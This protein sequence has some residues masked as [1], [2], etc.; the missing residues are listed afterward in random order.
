MNNEDKFYIIGVDGG[1]SKREVFY[2]QMRE[3]PLPQ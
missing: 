2:L 1:A 3:K